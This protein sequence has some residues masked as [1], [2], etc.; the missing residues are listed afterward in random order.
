M[1]LHAVT[2]RASKIELRPSFRGELI[3]PDDP[4]YDEA[5]AIWNA[6][7][8]KRPAL[9]ARCS[10]VADVIAAVNYAREHDL[11]LAV[12]GGG[13]NVAGTAL[14]DD[15]LVIDLSM[16]RGIRVDPEARIAWAQSGARWSDLDHES[17]QFGL[18]TPGGMVST[19]GVAGLTLGG[20]FGYLSRKFG[21]TC[22]NVL[23]ADIVTAD[24]RFLTA[25]ASENPD[26]F[27]ALRGGGGNFGVVTSFAFQLHRV[28][29]TVLAGMIV[30][31]LEEAGDVLRFFRE[32]ADD[33]PDEL[34]TLVVLLTAPP[35][36]FLPREIHGKPA[37]AIAGCYAGPVDEGEYVLRP[38]RS[39][40]QPVVD[41]F[42][43][44]SYERFQAMFDAAAPAGVHNYWKSEYLSE[45][46]DQ[47]IASYVDYASR[48]SSPLS[49]LFISHLG[50]AIGKV[51]EQ[52]TAVA[53]RGSKY[54]VHITSTWRD[55][56]ESETQIQWTRSLADAI[57]PHAA[58]G[59]YLNFLDA[60]EA[61]ERARSAYG[62]NYERL[63]EVKDRYDPTN[64]FRVN[65][66][67]RPTAGREADSLFRPER[68]RS[69]STR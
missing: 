42:G 16:M 44:E 10:G 4:G 21:L 37:I 51:D 69:M 57:R 2:G 13:H 24:G 63:V 3:S 19:T 45:L 28:G 36:P 39:F 18:A 60:D 14:C 50:G 34:G 5:R 40:G 12:R 48:L 35:A 68:R 22:D 38:L 26:L 56:S 47:V 55:P 32:Y 23:S 20:G 17:Q 8:D 61:S 1:A 25:S 7:V 53:N 58:G 11:P 33:I 41:L 59:S 6:M 64:L 15:G 67:I 9:I 66:N 29:P 65:T 54:L 49:H 27:W 43:P 62:V 31:P 46:D 52:S 30:Y